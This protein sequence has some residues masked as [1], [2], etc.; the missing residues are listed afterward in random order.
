M[1][2]TTRKAGSLEGI[3]MPARLVIRQSCNFSPHLRLYAVV[4][5]SRRPPQIKRFRDHRSI[6]S[7]LSPKPMSDDN[8]RHHPRKLRADE[9]S[10][11]RWGNTR[12]GVGN[13][14]RDGHGRIGKRC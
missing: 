12:E 1:P 4:R 3:S 6:L 5:A 11:A 2:T 8:G 13:R 14:P 9:R 7:L 10:D